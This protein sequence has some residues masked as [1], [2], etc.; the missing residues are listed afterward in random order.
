M[1]T[2]KDSKKREA[3]EGTGGP[4]CVLE[5]EEMRRDLQ[6]IMM[7]NGLRKEAKNLCQAF[8]TL[9][10]EGGQTD[11]RKKNELR[12]NI[13]GMLVKWL[14]ESIRRFRTAHA[15]QCL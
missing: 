12:A 15:Q 8:N 3:A 14:K 13:D 6:R 1:A 10:E 4:Q 9:L 2:E 5:L 11:D 7:Y